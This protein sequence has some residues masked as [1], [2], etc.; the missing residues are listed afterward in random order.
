MTENK[1]KIT[2][3]IFLEAEDIKETRILST[4]AFVTNFFKNCQNIY[5]NQSILD[6]ESDLEEYILRLYVDNEIEEEV[7]GCTKD[8]ENFIADIAEFLDLLAQA[9]SFLDMEGDFTIE[10][11]GNRETYQFKSEEGLNYCDFVKKL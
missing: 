5:L 9:Q 11:Q 2:Y 10:Y 6:D 8:A 1:L 4:K 3:K 7:C